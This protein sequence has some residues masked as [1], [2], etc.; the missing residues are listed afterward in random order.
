MIKGLTSTSL[1]ERW[2]AIAQIV[3]S[4]A[5]TLLVH[6]SVF[7]DDAHRF[8]R[9]WFA[10]ANSLFGELVATT[11]LLSGDGGQAPSSGEAS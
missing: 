1:V 6:E 4:D 5:D 11:V 9:S 7:A 3:D 2:E 8:T 10:W